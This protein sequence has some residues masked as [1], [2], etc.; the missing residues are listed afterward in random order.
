MKKLIIGLLLVAA[1]T[2]VFFFLRNKKDTDKPGNK[3]NSELLIGKWETIIQQE[4]DSSII[5]YKYEFQKNGNIIRTLND[6]TKT[7]SLIYEW[8]KA[9][10]LLIKSNAADTIT[11]VYKV[12]FNGSDSLIVKNDSTNMLFIK[13]K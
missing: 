5:H 7:D 4:N 9:G 1:G 13:L 6:S 10:D 12:I 8:D 3:E 11:K 2:G